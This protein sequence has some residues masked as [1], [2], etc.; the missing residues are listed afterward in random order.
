MAKA[1]RVEKVVIAHDTAEY[2]LVISEENESLHLV[3]HT[4]NVLGSSAVAGAENESKLRCPNHAG[5]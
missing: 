1:H 5:P 2:S 4:P 3:S